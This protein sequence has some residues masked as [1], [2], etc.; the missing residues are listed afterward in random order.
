MQELIKLHSSDGKY[1]G[2]TCYNR[3]MP[4]YHAIEEYLA[5]FCADPLH[6]TIH[7]CSVGKEAY[8]LAVHLD[9]LTENYQILALDPCMEF[10][11]QSEAHK[12][13]QYLCW[14][15]QEWDYPEPQQVVVMCN[16]ML[17]IPEDE[18]AD[19]IQQVAGY[20]SHLL[21]VTD[22]KE[23]V[24]LAAGYVKYMPHAE[25]IKSSWEHVPPTTKT[26]HILWEKVAR[27]E[28]LTYG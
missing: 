18:H 26:Q 16:M 11:V 28:S 7:G 21:A 1:I 15:V 5:L 6:I 14:P 8:T 12:N 3:N 23:D 17:Y 4:L 13:I 9:A 2:T 27:G 19:I 20:N 24:L 25:E 22:V 10:L